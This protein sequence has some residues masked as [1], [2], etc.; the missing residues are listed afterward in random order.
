M[1]YEELVTLFASDKTLRDKSN[2]I[3]KEKLKLEFNIEY[4]DNNPQEEYIKQYT[5]AGGI[6]P[7]SEEY[8]TV[9]GCI[10]R[11]YYL[12]SK[13]FKYFVDMSLKRKMIFS[14]IIIFM[15]MVMNEIDLALKIYDEYKAQG[16]NEKIL[17]EQ[18]IRGLLARG[19]ITKEDLD[20]MGKRELKYSAYYAGM[21]N[22]K[23]VELVLDKLGVPKLK[24]PAAVAK[25]I[26]RGA[27]TSGT[28]EIIMYVRKRI[29]QSVYYNSDFFINAASEGQSQIVRKVLEE[30]PLDAILPF[31]DTLL[32]GLIKYG[33]LQ[34]LEFYKK[35]GIDIKITKQEIDY[36][37]QMG[38][39]I[40]LMDPMIKNAA[41]IQAAY[42]SGVIKVINYVEG[43]IPTHDEHYKS[44]Y[45]G[46][47]IG[48]NKYLF[49]QLYEK[50]GDIDINELDYV[51]HDDKEMGSF[52][53]ELLK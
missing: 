23:T 30:F 49:L 32:V 34:E 36:Y 45:Y 27:G 43:E 52:V 48:G 28:T 35:Y 41:L 33:E 6:L 40:T 26:L 13:V 50:Y 53:K 19:E 1:P 44:K 16:V 14:G 15:A 25:L 18:I 51:T 39:D 2:Q 7:G 5:L 3:W 46:A 22:I 31:K 9:W 38:F 12:K 8:R 24:I 10:T 17:D 42:D 29:S 4:K 21:S 11:A 47:V 20:K 37:N